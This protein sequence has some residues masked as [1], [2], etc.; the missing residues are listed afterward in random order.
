MP[1]LIALLTDF[2]T[3]E[4]YVGVMKGVIAGI[5][6]DARVM[7]LAHGVPPQG[8]LV[9]GLWL[10][11]SAAFFP[12]ETIFVVVVDPGVGSDRRIVACEAGPWRVVC[13]DNGLLGPLLE[14]VALGRAVEVREPRYHLAQRSRTFHGRDVMAP[15]AAHLAAGVPLERLG[16]DAGDVARLAVP[17]PRRALDLGIGEVLYA[18]RFGNLVTSFL[19][20]DLPPAACV[21]CGEHEITLRGAYAEAEPGALL[22]LVGS[23]GR[24]EIAVRDGSA[25]GETGLAV[26]APVI[27][28]GEGPDG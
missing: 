3:T 4:P 27:V 13:P 6:P 10:A 16:P 28:T 15:V 20:A 11:E 9:A 26:G 24:L 22:A 17:R 19:A 1:P 23:S 14:R 21:R 12:A 8:V 7:D 5:A 25:A 18:D 2:G